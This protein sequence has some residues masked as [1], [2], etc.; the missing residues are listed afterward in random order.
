MDNGALG[1]YLSRIFTSNETYNDSSRCWQPKLQIKNFMP[2]PATCAGIISHME[3][4]LKNA[5]EIPVRFPD[6]SNV[7]VGGSKSKVSRFFENGTDCGGSRF[8]DQ[9]STEGPGRP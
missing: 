3:Y 9:E 5:S 4:E 2:F 7:F 6:L 8:P 1:L